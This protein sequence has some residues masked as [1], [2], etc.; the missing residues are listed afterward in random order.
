[1][2]TTHWVSTDI[3]IKLAN[4]LKTGTSRASLRSY[5]IGAATKRQENSQFYRAAQGHGHADLA[6]RALRQ[7]AHALL[8]FSQGIEGFARREVVDRQGTK[9]LEQLLRCIFK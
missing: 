6:G 8:Q 3:L 4:H 1:M 2:A 9:F 5:A 7:T